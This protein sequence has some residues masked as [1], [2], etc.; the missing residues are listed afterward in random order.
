M[1]KVIIIDDSPDMLSMLRV[2]FE[3]RT[4]YE[5]IAC[6]DGQE[7]L[8]QAFATRPSLALVDVMMPG[9]DGYE[10]VR[11]LRQNPTTQ[12]MGIIMLT[13]RGQPVDRQAALDA[14]ADA[15]V[16]KPVRFE[17]LEAVIAEVL[18]S[19]GLSPDGR[20]QRALPV[21][22]LKG[23]IGVTTVATNLA[24]MLQETTPTILWDLSPASGHAALFLGLKPQTHW[25][26]YLQD[27][28]QPIA[29]LLL[30]HASGLKVLCAPPKPLDAAI[31]N[32]QQIGGMLRALLRIAGTVVID[33]PP[34]LNEGTMALLSEAERIVLLTG[35]TPPAIQSTLVTLQALQDLTSKLL[36]LHNI[37]NPGRHPS[38]EVLQRVLRTPIH[39]AL[40]YDPA[41]EL[42]L[43]KGVPLAVVKRDSPFVVALREGCVPHLGGSQTA[44]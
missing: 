11:R 23:G 35:D 33:V 43:G 44:S 4:S 28:D 20:Q 2:F 25:G 17:E 42:T 6:K 26:T 15:H 5:V 40:P 34:L 16:T 14:G 27:P 37:S 9:I 7:G 36:L 21:L 22:S 10:V 18:A 19:I 13:A 30:E 24:V 29:S 1:V 41:Q 32:G 31:L 8:A 12:G 38:T 39:A 3:R